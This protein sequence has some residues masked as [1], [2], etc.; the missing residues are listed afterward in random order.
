[1]GRHTRWNWAAP[2][3]R[4]EK[5]FFL[6]ACVGLVVWHYIRHWQPMRWHY[7]PIRLQSFCNKAESSSPGYNLLVIYPRGYCPYDGNF[8]SFCYDYHIRRRCDMEPCGHYVQMDDR[9][10]QCE[11]SRSSLLLWSG[12]NLCAT[13]YEHVSVFQTL[14]LS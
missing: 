4:P 6:G 1:M 12:I 5:S 8:H 11:E 2:A 13:Q 7:E 3:S 14:Y 9:R 10:L